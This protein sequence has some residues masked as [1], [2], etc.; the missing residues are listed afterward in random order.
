MSAKSGDDRPI[1]KHCKKP[2][3]QV[4]YESHVS[5]CLETKAEN[6]R[7]KKE[8]KEAKAREAAAK[9]KEKEKQQAADKDKDKDGDSVMGGTAPAASQEDGD[10]AADAPPSAVTTTST[11]KPPSK[12]AT[13]ASQ[14]DGSSKKTKKRKADTEG[15]DK[16]PKKKK[17]KKD[18]PP[19]PKLP[20]PKGPVNV[21]IQ[22]G[23]PLDKE[24]GGYCARSL[25]CK[26]HSMGLKRAVPGRSLPYDQLLAMYQKKNQ[27]KQQKALME[28]QVGSAA[29]DDDAEGGVV[30]S[31]EERE[32]VMKA[33][34]RW[35]P[36][37][38]E[39]VTTVPMRRRYGYVR[40]KEM[41]GN[42]LAG[43]SQGKLFGPPPVGPVIGSEAVLDGVELVEAPSR[44]ASTA[45]AAGGGGGPSAGGTGGVGGAGAGAGHAH[46]VPKGVAVP[47]RKGSVASS[48]GAA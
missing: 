35:R 30:D 46:P 26:S 6:A 24:K 1:C 16:E 39:Q 25:T 2:V 31:E 45:G 28:A 44:K 9:A 12:S 5:H 3:E 17:L 37:P 21:E 29:V 23:V 20:K 33:L 48:V 47:V 13:K 22:C 7:K 27:A 34:G 43:G 14:A 18:E 11:K 38:L 4:H 8:R 41:L 32:S 42:A 19:R 40:I 15:N 36:R 10:K